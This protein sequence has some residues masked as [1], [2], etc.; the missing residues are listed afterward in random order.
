MICWLKRLQSFK[1]SFMEVLFPRYFFTRSKN[2][3]SSWF[4]A[5]VDGGGIGSGITG[6]KVG[7]TAGPSVASA[8]LWASLGFFDAGPPAPRLPMGVTSAGETMGAAVCLSFRGRFLDSLLALAGG[9]KLPS[10]GIF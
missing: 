4:A 6:V 8:L 7:S 10:G 3:I 1:N 5:A 9:A 2:A